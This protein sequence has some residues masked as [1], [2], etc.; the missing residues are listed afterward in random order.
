MARG[1]LKRTLKRTPLVHRKKKRVYKKKH[2]GRKIIKF[3]NPSANIPFFRRFRR[4]ICGLPIIPRYKSVDRITLCLQALR[5]SGV[6]FSH[7]ISGSL[8]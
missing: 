2:R 4:R 5:V 6:N 1:K 3:S 7:E 8:A